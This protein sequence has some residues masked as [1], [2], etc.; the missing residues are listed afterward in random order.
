[1]TNRTTLLFI[2][3]GLSLT[4]GWLPSTLQAQQPRPPLTP[5]QQQQIED[6]LG[7]I[8][9]PKSQFD[10]TK[11]PRDPSIPLPEYREDPPS[12]WLEFLKDNQFLAAYIFAG[13]VTLALAIVVGIPIVLARI[14]LG[15]IN[16][17]C[18]CRD[19]DSGVG[20]RAPPPGDGG[21]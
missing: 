8:K 2:E 3:A 19:R 18:S 13:A 15:L 10:P 16:V 20:P 5:A 9:E 12:A 21:R 4:L 1:M 6:M 14:V 7:P 11:Y 17:L